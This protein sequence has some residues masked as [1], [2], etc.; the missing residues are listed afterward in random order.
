M[1]ISADDELAIRN[2]LGRYADAVCRRDPDDWIATWAPDC[3]WDLGG[4]RVTYG[5]EDTLGLWHESIAKYEWVAQLPSSGTIDGVD[6]AAGGAR[7]DWYILE[8]NRTVDGAGV[9]HLGHYADTYA[10]TA[11]GWRFQTRRFH[12]VY[13][14][15]MDPG[16]LRQWKGAEQ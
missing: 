5:H 16:E 10:K 7:G 8:L 13:R 1:A 9:L 11:E 15:A 12:L 14:G 4:G 2:L 3:M 6:S